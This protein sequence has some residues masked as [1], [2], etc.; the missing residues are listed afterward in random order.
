MEL[1]KENVTIAGFGMDTFSVHAPTGVD[2]DKLTTFLK[3]SNACQREHISFS[4]TYKS[5][6]EGFSCYVFG[7][8]GTWHL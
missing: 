4:H 2:T 6:E 3:E 8:S 1:S 5:E 7:E